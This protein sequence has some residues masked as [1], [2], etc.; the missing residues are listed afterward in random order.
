[1][2]QQ[3]PLPKNKI[4]VA[5]PVLKFQEEEIPNIFLSSDFHIEHK[6]IL[7]FTNRGDVFGDV[8][9]MNRGLLASV[10]TPVLH[11]KSDPE[12]LVLIHCGDLLFGSRAQSQ[13]NYKMIQDAL[14]CYSR[15]YAV[16]GNHDRNNIL[17]QHNLIMAYSGNINDGTECN[18]KWYWNTM[19]IVEIYRGSKC[20]A[21]F[22]VSHFPMTEF[23]G[24]FNIHGH[25]HSHPG[26]EP[27]TESH[28]AWL[29]WLSTGVHFDCGVDNNNYKPVCLADIL[30]GKTSIHIENI[31]Q[32][33]NLKFSFNNETEEAE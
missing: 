1:M 28:K 11:P 21:V 15:V 17:M 22:T 5:P 31:P 30:S 4:L 20:I 29:G 14:D 18:T 16:A 27:D 6:N 25:L 12:K 2:A 13:S 7:S 23:H 3:Q 32:L 33:A 24:S 8:E 9:N 10:N 19:F 26:V